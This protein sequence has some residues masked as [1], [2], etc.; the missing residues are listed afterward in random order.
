VNF[1][2]RVSGPYLRNDGTSRRPLWPLV[3]F[4]LFCTI[5][6][7]YRAAVEND[8][9]RR[10]QT[11]FGTIVQC[12]QRG[13]GN[14]NY[15]HYTFPVGDEKYEGVSKAEQGLEFGQTAMVYYDGQDPQVSALEDFSEQ[16]RKSMRFV[17]F[18]LLTLAATVTF[19]LWDRATPPALAPIVLQ[20]GLCESTPETPESREN[21]KSIG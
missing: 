6:F 9:A 18:F 7:G 11:S 1:F 5:F 3:S 14:E 21:R 20:V 12:Q 16:R 15:C 19:I 10:Q 4:L 2:N 17:Y 13:R 8:S